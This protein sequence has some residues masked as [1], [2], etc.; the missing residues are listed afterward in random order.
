MF[1]TIQA[2]VFFLK[3]SVRSVTSL[4]I[5]ENCKIFCDSLP[6]PVILEEPSTVIPFLVQ[7]LDSSPF[8]LVDFSCILH[9]R[10]SVCSRAF[11][12]P[13]HRVAIRLYTKVKSYFHAPAV[14]IGLHKNLMSKHVHLRTNAC[15]KA[16]IAGEEKGIKKTETKNRDREDMEIEAV[17]EDGGGLTLSSLNGQE[18]EISD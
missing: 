7:D 3:I 13:D 17:V 2:T 4:H 14:V 5:M 10:C 8:I 1:C 16:P 11:L 15:C 6:R 12:R 18:V 9:C